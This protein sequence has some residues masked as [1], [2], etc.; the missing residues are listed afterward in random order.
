MCDWV[1][2]K[3]DPDDG[4]ITALL[5]LLTLGT[6]CGAAVLDFTLPTD[7]IKGGAKAPWQFG[8]DSA[9]L[10]GVI[11]FTILPQVISRFCPRQAVKFYTD[12]IPAFGPGRLN[13]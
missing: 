13:L 8:L 1:Q 5:Y 11:L 9:I 3:L 7:V 6:C 4:E 2:V 10:F 12:D